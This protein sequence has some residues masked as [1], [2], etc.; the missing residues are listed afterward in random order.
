[1]QFKRLK[2]LN[3]DG[4]QVLANARPEMLGQG[5][6]G[7]VWL[8]ELWSQRYAFKELADADEL[9]RELKA[10]A[11][12]DHPN[13]MRLR[14]SVFDANDKRMGYLMDVVDGGNLLD[15]IRRPEA[16]GRGLPLVCRLGC[17]IADGLSYLHARSIVHRDLHI[18]NVLMRGEQAVISDFNCGRN[19][20]GPS[21]AGRSKATAFG[22]MV[23]I[24]PPECRHSQDYARYRGD[25]DMYG[26]GLMMAQL[27]RA[28]IPGQEGWQGI[29]DDDRWKIDHVAAAVEACNAAGVYK[30][31]GCIVQ[32]CV[33]V[34]HGKQRPT[35][36]NVLDR[37]KALVSMLD[38]E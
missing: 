38:S 19:L 32:Q 8:I 30:D 31:V 26:Y 7:Q 16:Q 14:L 2:F 25:Y 21:M 29:E 4:S 20:S 6:F 5:S 9:N 3:A 24:V 15:Y 34:T 10:M 33:T 28:V 17:E 27:V 22:G 12:L 37:L 35:A 23:S 36:S 13:L 1:M 18:K 11:G